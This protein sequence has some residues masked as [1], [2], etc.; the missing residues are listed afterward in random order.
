M[1]ESELSQKRGVVPSPNWLASVLL[2][3]LA[4]WSVAEIPLESKCR[5]NS[6]IMPLISL[7][8]Y[9]CLYQLLKKK[10]GPFLIEVCGN[11]M[12]GCGLMY[13]IFCILFLLTIP[14]ALA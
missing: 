9:V 6:E 2:S 7:D 4:R 11:N 10:H 14:L 5:S 12:G 1:L 3:K 8:R 13:L